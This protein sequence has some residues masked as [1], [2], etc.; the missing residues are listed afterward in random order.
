MKKI[1]FNKGQWKIVEDLLGRS[2]AL[3]RTIETL[4][5]R[6]KTLNDSMWNFIKEEFPD[7]TNFKNAK[8]DKD[9]KCMILEGVN[10]KIITF[11][12][13]LR[14]KVKETN[15]ELL[16]ILNQNIDEVADEIGIKL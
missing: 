8:I 10:P 2:D 6:D 5:L 7:C 11:Y 4:S 1:E 12:S 9:G 13:K 15:P 14:E 16:P 3:N